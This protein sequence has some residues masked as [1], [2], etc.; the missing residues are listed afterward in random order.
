MPPRRAY[1]GLP[2]RNWRGSSKVPPAYCFPGTERLFVV[3][4]LVATLGP[5]RPRCCSE[6]T[7]ISRLEATTYGRTFLHTR[8]LL[9]T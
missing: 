2:C 8:A 9:V 4:R 1:S 3:N 5:L 7:T 6:S